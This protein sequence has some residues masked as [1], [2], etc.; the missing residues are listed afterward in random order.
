[1]A[2]GYACY[3]HSNDH[4]RAAVANCSKCGKALCTEC[5]D[6]F[7]S[8]RTGKILC[9][10]CLNGEIANNENLCA[11]AAARAKK[12]ITSMIV[13]AVLGLI[14][15]I[16]LAASVP[17]AGLIAFLIVPFLFASF[18]LIWTYSF[19]SFGLVIG[20]I[21]FIVMAAISPIMFIIRVVK[22]VKNRKILAQ[23]IIFNQ[24][25]RAANNEFLK[26]AR[27]CKSGISAAE[28]Q[29]LVY[30]L[31]TAQAQQNALKEDLARQRQAL[32]AAQ[33]SGDAAETARLTQAIEQLQK[34]QDMTNKNMA[35]MQKQMDESGAQQAALNKD[36]LAQV[37]NNADG[38]ADTAYA[39]NAMMSSGKKKAA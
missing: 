7:R 3:H 17:G 24:E 28:M 11:R 18:G 25:A 26:Y 30:Q 16:I 35:T 33:Q 14:V 36:I 38:L 32:A 9:I 6:L 37:R 10:E 23:A 15:A 20:L 2:T 34:A 31:Q 1:M 27:S 19:G 13:G 5:T 22:R 4:D 12:E 39:V 21:A 29:K 8:N